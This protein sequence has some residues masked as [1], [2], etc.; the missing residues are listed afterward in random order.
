MVVRLILLVCRQEASPMSSQFSTSDLPKLLVSYLDSTEWSCLADLGCGEGVI[1]EA[2]YHMGYF[3]GKSIFAV[4][5]S[6]ERLEKVRSISQNVICVNADASYT[7]IES[8][9]V[10]L[11]ISTQV[12]EHVD[13]DNAMVQEIHR[14]LAPGGTAYI[15]TIFKKWYGWY[16]YRCNGKW[17]IDP[18]H[19][20][21]YRT[22]GQLL[23]LFPK[24]GLD[25]QSTNKTL[26]RV[27][28]LDSVLRRLGASRDVY[29]NRILRMLRG[30]RLPIP[31]YYIWEVVC[32]KPPV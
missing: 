12:I 29:N 11:V 3:A 1:L 10:D 20:R 26:R 23:D 16:F 31:G 17:T 28:L 15:D 7:T 18:T 5:Q 9:S 4:D 14:I 24:N 8:G 32:Q 2:L 6:A 25:V 21:E 30:I 19:L 22:D 27:P 13:D